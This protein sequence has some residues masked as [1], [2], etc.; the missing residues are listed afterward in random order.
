MPLPNFF[1]LGLLALA[2]LGSAQAQTSCVPAPPDVAKLVA[3]R[4]GYHKVVGPLARFDPCHASVSL[5]M[6][7]FFASRLGEKPPLMIIAHG[8]GGPGGAEHEMVRRMNSEGVATLLYDAYAMNG[9]NYRGT[10]LFVLGVTNESRQR[11]IFKATFGAYQW[12]KQVAEIDTSR[13]YINGLSNGGSVA[14][15]MAGV[16]EPA[17]VQ[18]VIA[19]GASPTGLGFPDQI[20]V[21]L[22]LVYGRQDNYGGAAQDDWM[23]Q[24]TDPCSFNTHYALAPPGVAQ[25]CSF[26]TNPQDMVQ[27]PMDWLERVKAQGQPIDVWFYDDAA[28]GILAGSIKQGTRNYGTGPTAKLRYGWTGSAAGVADRYIADIVVLI[29]SSYP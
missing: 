14:V 15:N 10:M 28:H 1:Y 29:K 23:Y 18:A 7:S 25:R 17:H 6:P 9:F 11:M 5:S 12:A 24:R 19:E 3:I 4:P 20:K 13:I 8:G 27:T 26:K 22:K 16:V 2:N 21:P